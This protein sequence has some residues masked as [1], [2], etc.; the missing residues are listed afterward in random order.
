M[1]WIVDLFKMDDSRIEWIF[2][3]VGDGFGLGDQKIFLEFLSKDDGANEAVL[4][5]FLNAPATGEGKSIILYMVE[6][7]FQ[8]EKTIEI[9]KL[10]FKL[11][12]QSICDQH[13]SF[14]HGS[15]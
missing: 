3:K 15:G 2:K 8:E 7:E 11:W 14:Y 1:R 10:T 4:L 9:G 5:D 12:F 6:E 13:D